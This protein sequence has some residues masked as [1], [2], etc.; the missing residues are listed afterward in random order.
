M[1]PA[2]NTTL[3][4]SSNKLKNAYEELSCLSCPPS[5][6]QYGFDEWYLA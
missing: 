2:H 6:S 5:F 1:S 4:S 3:F